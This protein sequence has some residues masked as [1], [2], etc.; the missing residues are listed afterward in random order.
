M[1]LAAWETDVVAEGHGGEEGT[2]LGGCLGC[3]A[4]GVKATMKTATKRRW[5][6]RSGQRGG[7]DARWD[8]EQDDCEEERAGGRNSKRRGSRE[9]ER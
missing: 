7:E 6:W 8:N 2:Q 5:W 3:K 1:E 4:K 9:T